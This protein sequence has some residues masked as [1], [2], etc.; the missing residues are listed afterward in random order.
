MFA[1]G[2]TDAVGQVAESG[3]MHELGNRRYKRRRLRI[4]LHDVPR[5]IIG[6]DGALRYCG[7]RRHLSGGAGN[8]SA[9]GLEEGAAAR[10]LPADRLVPRP[11]DVPVRRGAGRALI[12][13]RTPPY[14]GVGSSAIAAAGRANDIAAPM[15]AKTESR[16][17]TS[18][19]ADNSCCGP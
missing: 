9:T 17:M 10:L 18:R 16:T 7:G 5:P 12:T 11:M 14:R 8:Q 13:H 19:L 6:C 4:A 2:P 3:P 1:R 15:A